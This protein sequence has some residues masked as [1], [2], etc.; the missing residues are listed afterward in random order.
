LD[1]VTVTSVRY[2]HTVNEFLLPKQRRRDVDLTTIWLEQHGATAH[3]DRQSM[4]TLRIVLEHRIISR[5]G[6][7]SWPARSPDVG[8]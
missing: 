6:D 3:T 8:L 7:I 1:A 2:V 4:I 5:Y